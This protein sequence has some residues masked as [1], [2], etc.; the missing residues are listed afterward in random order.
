M[1]RTAATHHD[2]G[3]VVDGFLDVG[4][5]T[6]ERRIDLDAAQS[7]SHRRQRLLHTA[8]NFEGAAIGPLFDHQQESGAVVEYRIADQRLMVFDHGS[9]VTEAQLRSAPSSVTWAM[10]AGLVIGE[11]CWMPI[12][13]F[14][15]SMKPPV[16][17]T[18]ASTKLRGEAQSALA[19][20]SMTSSSG[21]RW[22]C[23][24]C[25]IG[26]D[27][28]LLLALSPDRD[29]GDARYAHEP[30]PDVPACQNRHLD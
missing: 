4:G 6:V 2:Q 30:R 7:G 21:T 1:T 15:V 20:A 3:E 26:K 24:L 8:R 18:A 10:S 28:K 17:G 23:S 27:L 5:R 14:G 29:V 16:P 19:V 11:M 25:R 22:A 12:L 9:D 13:W